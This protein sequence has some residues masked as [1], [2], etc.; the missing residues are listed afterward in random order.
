MAKNTLPRL[1]QFLDALRFEAL[2][3]LALRFWADHGLPAAED[4]AA[5]LEWVTDGDRCEACGSMDWVVT[6][7]GGCDVCQPG[8]LF[9]DDR[10]CAQLRGPGEACDRGTCPCYH[11]PGGYHVEPETVAKSL[12]WAR[13]ALDVLGTTHPGTD[14]WKVKA[15]ELADLADFLGGLR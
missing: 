3:A 5:F 12:A 10:L 11:T 13:G 2:H 1:D 15:L 8:E 9:H 4:R 7:A 14:Q 6:W